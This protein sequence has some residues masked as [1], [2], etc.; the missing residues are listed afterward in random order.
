MK[1]TD[2]L[3]LRFGPYKTPKFNNGDIVQCEVWGEVEIVRVSDAPIQWPIGKRLHKRRGR[4]TLAVFDSCSAYES[5]T[6]PAASG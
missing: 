5:F 3:K 1:D 2:R 6:G 4:P